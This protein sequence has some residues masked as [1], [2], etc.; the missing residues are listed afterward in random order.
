M[1]LTRRQEEFVQK[2]IELKQEF[3]GPVRYSLLAERLG[4]SPFTAYDMLCLLEEKGFVTSEYQLPT[5]KSGPGRAERVFYPG[6]MAHAH[7]Q[8]IVDEISGMRLE[9]EALKEYLLEKQR[10][11][12]MPN[13]DKE[14]VEQLMV[15]LL[16]AGQGNVRYCVEVLTVAALRL[17]YGTGRQAFWEHFPYILR[18]EGD[19][20]Q[21][22]LCL[23][24]GFIFGILAQQSA[25]GQE[26]L[27]KLREHLQGYLDAVMEMGR[28]DCNKLAA[29]LSGVFAA[30]GDGQ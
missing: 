8:R 12:G 28:E 10:Q 5:D 19:A 3:D 4:V 29:Q 24:G 7:E 1:K 20:C 11:G 2:M 27:S 6:E 21:A 9:G 23:L 25:P 16:P 14:L 30:L 18:E 17:Q 15:R 13:G 26:W 22:N